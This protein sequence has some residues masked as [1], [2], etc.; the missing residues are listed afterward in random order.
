[1]LSRPRP[2][3]AL[4][5]R[6]SGGRESMAPGNPRAA[7]HWVLCTLYWVLRTSLRPDGLAAAFA[8]ADAHA[9]FEREDED[10]AVADL[11]RLGGPRRMH[12]GLDGRLGEGVV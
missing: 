5:A 10:L 11:P 9:V 6:S 8:G 3:L 2:D 1:M 12:D 7:G 4:E